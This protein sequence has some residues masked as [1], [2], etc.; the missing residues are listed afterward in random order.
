MISKCILVTSPLLATLLQTLGSCLSSKKLLFQVTLLLQLLLYKFHGR[1]RRC[2]L[3]RLRANSPP[4]NNIFCTKQLS[5]WNMLR[6]Y[7]FP[8]ENITL[9]KSCISLWHSRW[10]FSLVERVSSICFSRRSCHVGFYMFLLLTQEKPGMASH[11]I[12]SWQGQAL[13]A[14]T[15]KLGNV[16]DNQCERTCEG[17]DSKPVLADLQ[18]PGFVCLRLQFPFQLRNFHV[19]RLVQLVGNKN[20]KNT[21]KTRVN[22]ASPNM[23][24]AL[25][26][27]VLLVEF[28]LNQHA[29]VQLCLTN[30]WATRNFWKLLPTSQ[31]F[32]APCFYLVFVFGKAQC[33]SRTWILRRA[34]ASRSRRCSISMRRSVRW[35]TC[36]KAIVKFMLGNWFGVPFLDA[37]MLSWILISQQFARQDWKNPVQSPACWASISRSFNAW[38]VG[39]SVQKAKMLLG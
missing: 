33:S 35:W 15:T 29:L 10:V 39:R 27:S 11:H 32:L 38:P 34:S 20:P 30:V 18:V 25:L 31:L 5:I 6:T 17:M 23:F 8:R 3:L 4:S 19:L 16:P 36:H 26:T 9:K 13:Q 22:N 7:K 28:A 21:E 12:I 1:K 24:K 14:S 2:K 37:Y